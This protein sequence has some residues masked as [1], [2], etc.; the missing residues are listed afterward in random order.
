M[1]LDIGPVAFHSPDRNHEVR[2]TCHVRRPLLFRLTTTLLK[3]KQQ[4]N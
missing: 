4:S 1:H 2:R 3:R